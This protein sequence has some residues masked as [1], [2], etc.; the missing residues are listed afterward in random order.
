MARANLPSSYLSGMPNAVEP[1][2]QANPAA[3]DGPVGDATRQI[4][5]QPVAQSLP[6]AGVTIRKRLSSIVTASRAC[7]SLPPSDL[8]ATAAANP[9]RQQIDLR[10]NTKKFDDLVASTGSRIVALDVLL[11]WE[12]EYNGAGHVVWGSKPLLLV[13]TEPMFAV[14]R[15]I[16]KKQGLKPNFVLIESANLFND[17]T[18]YIGNRG[19]LVNRYNLE[20]LV[21]RY[22]DYFA[23]VLAAD[24]SENVS[25]SCT[26]VATRVIAFLEA[27]PAK[28]V[29]TDFVLLGV[30][31]GYGLD[32][33]VAF[34]RPRASPFLSR[35][36]SPA[37]DFAAEVNGR[38]AASN[39]L[40]I[41]PF[42]SWPGK[43]SDQLIQ[44]YL[45]ESID[46]KEVF[47]TDAL[48]SPDPV[49]AVGAAFRESIFRQPQDQQPDHP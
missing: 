9:R 23:G 21:A 10:G 5:P 4:A 7:F 16:E 40:A 37:Q 13:E 15:E 32:N 8:P 47:L 2:G 14:L 29:D 44:Q 41:P 34:D 45:N 43:E 20:K 38:P 24:P 46:I 27:L 35:H 30:L 6:R 22:P 11:S 3:G 1:V 12:I 49:V 19:F 39:L 26:D 42:A 48:A 17:H 33:A 18:E 31:L 25:A 28:K 36:G